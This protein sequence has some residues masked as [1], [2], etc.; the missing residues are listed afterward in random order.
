MQASG[1]IGKRGSELL[2]ELIMGKAQ[3][4]RPYKPALVLDLVQIAHTLPQGRRGKPS[5]LSFMHE[6]YHML[7]APGV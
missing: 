5:S 6:R 4:R 2:H 1:M 3:D 7:P